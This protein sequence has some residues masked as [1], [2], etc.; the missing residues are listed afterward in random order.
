MTSFSHSL[1]HILT[2]SFFG[3]FFIDAIDSPLASSAAP[4]LA[5]AE[6]DIPPAAHH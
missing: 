5:H 6:D 4:H 2:L 1:I 3:I